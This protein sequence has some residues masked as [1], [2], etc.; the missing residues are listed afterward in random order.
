MCG[1]TYW[2]KGRPQCG[3]LAIS[4]DEVEGKDRGEEA[5]FAVIAKSDQ[6]MV[7]LLN[8]CSHSLSLSFEAYVY[9]RWF[10]NKHQLTVLL[11]W[12]GLEK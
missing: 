6:I 9:G 2:K 10:V 3:P 7:G 4:T 12:A 11:S 5:D 1:L 8:N